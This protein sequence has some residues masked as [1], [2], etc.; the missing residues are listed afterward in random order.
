MSE[1]KDY[2]KIERAIEKIAFEKLEKSLISKEEVT[3]GLSQL[4]IDHKSKNTSKKYTVPESFSLPRNFTKEHVALLII[5]M[6]EW[7]HDTAMY[8]LRLMSPVSSIIYAPSL[9]C[10]YNPDNELLAV[11]FAAEYMRYM[12]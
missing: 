7:A 6:V 8:F 12:R 3:F 2:L 10:K 9:H 4:L 5:D 11:F 1:S